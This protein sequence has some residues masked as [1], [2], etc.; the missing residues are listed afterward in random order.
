MTVATVVGKAMEMQR[1]S[2]A[3]RDTRHPV[4][5]TALAYLS[6]ALA[7]ERYEECISLLSI[8]REFGATEAEIHK[9]L[10][11][12]SHAL[13]GGVSFVCPKECTYT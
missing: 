2:E 6:G 7:N 3:R 4:R 5:A 8:A 10:M 11:G 9:V 1:A 12:A 13:S